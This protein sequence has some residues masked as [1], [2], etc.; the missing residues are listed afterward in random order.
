MGKKTQASKVTTKRVNP[1]R[2]SAQEQYA[3]IEKQAFVACVAAISGCPLALLGVGMIPGIIGLVLGW[4]AKRADGSRPAG[5]IVAIVF[6][7]ISIILGIPGWLVIYGL[8]INP[9]SPFI[10]SLVDMFVSSS[11]LMMWF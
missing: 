1:Y 7:I 11:N 4:K 9:G 2:G 6:G 5:A 10:K 8:Y 3:R